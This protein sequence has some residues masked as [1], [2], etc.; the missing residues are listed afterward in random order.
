MDGTLHS[1]KQY[2]LGSIYRILYPLIHIFPEFLLLQDRALDPDRCAFR[3]HLSHGESGAIFDSP[4]SKIH[5]GGG[6]SC[7]VWDLGS[8]DLISKR[9]LP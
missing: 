7:G 1:L 8:L 3:R 9:T 4:A 2:T 5:L 6:P